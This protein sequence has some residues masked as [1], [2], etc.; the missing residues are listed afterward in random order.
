MKLS[1]SLICG[2]LAALFSS[3]G[4]VQT[5]HA[6]SNP[7]ASPAPRVLADDD[8]VGPIA[9][10]GGTLDEFLGMLERLSGRTLL[11][12]QNLP[13]LTLSLDLKSNVTR[14]EALQAIESL[15]NLNGVATTPLGTRFFKVTPLNLAKSEAPEFL[16]GTTLGLPPSGR[17]ASKLFVLDFL[18]VGEFMP[19]IAG[20]LN[21]AA[22]SPPIVFDKNNSA[23]LTDSISN[24]QR[25][26][27]LI[28][29]L[30]QP[31]L[32]GMR[33]KFY[34]LQSGAK[35]SD[36]VNKMRTILSGPLQ[37]QLGSATTYNADDRTN[38]V[39]LIADPRQ[40]PFFDELIAKLDV[41]SDP[42]TRN[43]VIYLKHAAS[44]DV[45][46][47][48]TQL[49]TGQNNAARNQGQDANRI[50]ASL[51][52]LPT[53]APAAGAAPVSVP[54]T[55][56]IT[57]PA[58]GLEVSNQFSPLLT[59]LSEERSNSIVVSGTI[60]DIRLINELVSKIDVL[61]A[62]VRI[63]VVIAEVTLTDN[64][65]SGISALGLQVTN[66]KL[67]GASI[68]M[69]GA[70]SDNITGTRQPTGD[71]DLSAT[72][73]LST[74]PRKSNATILSQPNIITT[75]NKE[76]KIF[77]GE[78]RP[79]ISSYINDGTTTGGSNI[80]SGYRS[81]VS[82]KDIGIDLTVKPLIGNDGSVQLEIKQE[83]NDV[84]GEIVIDGN[85]QPRIGRRTTESFVSVRSGEIIVLGGLQR[86]SKSKSTSRLGPIPI[87]GDLLG[88]RT[89]EDTRTDLVFFLRPTVLTNTAA[90]NKSALE[91][92]EKLPKKDRERIQQAIQPAGTH[93]SAPVQ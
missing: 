77:V 65:K 41:R 37:V 11:R 54:T 83:V 93:A 8:I 76:G 31:L 1:T 50:T 6:Q 68:V 75:H 29:Q 71:M 35:A 78:Q 87:I 89:R 81:N 20:L 82:S 38:Q 73:A 16:E 36:V 18:R 4:S 51:P 59:V 23:L 85:P 10:P 3:V 88:S 55:V 7:P 79:V 62:Q 49:V 19:Q 17:I 14:A 84:L 33:T 44:K 25:V 53:A 26:E 92:I 43:E 72:I 57:G 34:P 5:A 24:L 74:T 61:L 46:A 80:G 56:N 28:A 48:L 2:V 63:E 66:D 21:P 67:V 70:S 27:S 22:G 9:I 30:D 12:S 42:N 90:D 69:A 64:A 58:L 47:I 52:Q 60:D 13:S 91:Q 15:L 40:Y 45:A 32:N 39:V 86:T